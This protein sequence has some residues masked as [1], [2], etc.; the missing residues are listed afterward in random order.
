MRY[1]PFKSLLFLLMAA[2][3]A[4]PLAPQG[5][6]TS[7]TAN[8]GPSGCHEDAPMVPAPAPS[9]HQCCQSGHDSA[10]L[11]ASSSS[12][13]SLHVLTLIDLPQGAV[14]LAVL[15]TLPGLA[16]AYGDPPMLLPLRV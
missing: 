11:L 13:L 3:L 12:G 2:L 6:P 1:F 4:A 8:D 10:I 9:T 15:H 14:P 5:L 7:A 16:I